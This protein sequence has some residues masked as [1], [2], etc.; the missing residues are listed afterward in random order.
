MAERCDLLTSKMYSDFIFHF[1]IVALCDN[2]PRFFNGGNY[3]ER[4]FRSPTSDQ[5]ASGR[6]IGGRDL[7]APGPQSSLVSYLVASVSKPGP[8]WA[9]RSDAIQR[10]TSEDLSRT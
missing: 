2:R 10:A 9:I 1:T 7:W 5:T 6:T 3:G 8:Q 4:T